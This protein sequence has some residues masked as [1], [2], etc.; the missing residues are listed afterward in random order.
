[1]I[2]IP[3][4][5]AI[6]RGQ[7][8]NMAS[9]HINHDTVHID[10]HLPDHLRH[11]QGSLLVNRVNIDRIYGRLV[12]SVTPV[13]IQPVTI[14]ESPHY[15]FITGDHQPY[16]NYLTLTKYPDHTTEKFQQLISDFIYLGNEYRNHYIICEEKDGNYYIAVSYTHLRLPTN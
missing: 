16:K 2:R 8:G 4:E 7:R 1:M 13:V 6:V 9:N 3:V 12:T 15:K 5:G 11:L 10:V 14:K